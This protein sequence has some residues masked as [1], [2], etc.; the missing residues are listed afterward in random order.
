M[1]LIWCQR[2]SISLADHAK[3]ITAYFDEH[4]A[5]HDLSKRDEHSGRFFSYVV[6]QCWPKMY[7]RVSCWLGLS[8]PYNWL[9]HLRSFMDAIDTYH[10]EDDITLRSRGRGD[11]M[12][13]TFL[14]SSST[15]MNNLEG[16]LAIILGHHKGVGFLPTL[17][18]RAQLLSVS[19]ECDEPLYTKETAGEFH[20][21]VLAGLLLLG[22]S[23]RI[24]DD[25]FGKASNK[26]F[27]AAKT[28]KLKFT[29]MVLRLVTYIFSSHA[30][31]SHIRIITKDGDDVDKLMPKYK[32]YAS[33]VHFGYEQGIR[34]S[35]EPRIEDILKTTGN[36]NKSSVANKLNDGNEA[37]TNSKL[38]DPSSRNVDP[39]L[40]TQLATSGNCKPDAPSLPPILT[41][42]PCETCNGRLQCQ[43]V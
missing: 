31:K 12:L 1:C 17:L 29:G 19:T 3:T 43:E 10:W 40:L 34:K 30:Y 15:T 32:D 39:D 27:S 5:L 8:L 28:D 6:S 25:E 41:P 35:L 42:S 26:E 2:D 23:L 37:Q 13:V 7:A 36:S 14:N 21:L 33:Y 9:S 24:V 11:R 20:L 38:G 4:K 22:M 16:I 18:K